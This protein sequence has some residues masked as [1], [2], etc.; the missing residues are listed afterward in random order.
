MAEKDR[1]HIRRL[2]EE[3]NAIRKQEQAKRRRNRILAQIGIIVGAVVVIGSIVALVV[4]GPRWFN[5]R[6]EFS[7]A[8]TVEVAS[9]LTG[10][11]VEL[12]ISSTER[13]GILVGA[14]DAPVTLQYWYDYSCSHC[15]AYHE[16]LGQSY[17]DVLATG[18]VKVEYIP[19]N[20]VSPYGAQAG[21]A[22]LALVQY[23]PAAFFDFTDAVFS[24]DSTTQT[25]WEGTEYAELLSQIG[26]TSEEAITATQDG[27]FLRLVTDNTSLARSVGVQGTPSVGVNEVLLESVPAS[28]EELF[29]TVKDAGADVE[30]PGQA[31][32]EATPAAG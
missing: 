23:Q 19:I 13:G 28:A 2:R 20:F 1:D 27:T 22:A 17:Q 9:S 12:P 6:P 18:Q 29:Q 24:I 31:Q 32:T 16:A 21:A 25:S 15:L 3:A 4:F 7:S 8:G 26:V 11:S 14:D 30:V 5:P 10:E